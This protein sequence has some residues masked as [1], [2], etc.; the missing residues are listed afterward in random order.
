MVDGR[1]RK[2]RV[3]S[4]RVRGERARR[5]PKFVTRAFLRQKFATRAF[6]ATTKFE[7]SSCIKIIFLHH[8]LLKILEKVKIVWNQQFLFV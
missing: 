4:S 8:K 7:S 5:G 2:G 6:F 1:P 3:D